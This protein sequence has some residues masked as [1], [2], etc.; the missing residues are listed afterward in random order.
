MPKG[1]RYSEEV[2]SEAVALYESGEPVAEINRTFNLEKT[3]IYHF[4]KSRG[5]PA[6]SKKNGL[7]KVEPE[8]PGSHFTHGVVTVDNEGFVQTYQRKELHTFEIVFTGNLEVEAESLE[9]AIANAR[10]R[11]FVGCIHSVREK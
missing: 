4:L 9:E 11:T 2:I 8:V 5:I 3:T 1:E 6:R 10:K 7:V